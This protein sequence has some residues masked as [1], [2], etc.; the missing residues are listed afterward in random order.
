MTPVWPFTHGMHALH[1][2]GIKF[3]HATEH[4]VRGKCFWGIVVILALLTAL[5]ALASLFGNPMPPSPS[6]SVINL[7]SKQNKRG[8]S[9]SSWL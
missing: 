4:V 1:D 9:L 6:I 5:F 7:A 2:S 3:L 8:K